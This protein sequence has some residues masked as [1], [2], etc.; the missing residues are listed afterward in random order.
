MFKTQFQQTLKCFRSNA[1]GEYDNKITHEFMTSE[2]ITQELTASDT[3][4]QNDLA[5]QSNWTIIEKARAQQLTT[6]LSDNL[7]AEA[8]CTAI[9]LANRSPTRP[10]K[11]KEAGKSITPYEAWFEWRLNLVYI[12]IF[13][14]IAFEHDYKTK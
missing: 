12:Q 10:L 5:E 11:S 3:S 7:W 13:G 6:N 4:D 2:E 1:E 9:Y 14:C 8:Y